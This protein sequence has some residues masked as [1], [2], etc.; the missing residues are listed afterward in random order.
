MAD[1]F[2]DQF[3]AAA[4]KEAAVQLLFASF[5]EMNKDLTALEYISS[6]TGTVQRPIL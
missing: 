6:R 5:P 2:A 4:S 3:R 1:R